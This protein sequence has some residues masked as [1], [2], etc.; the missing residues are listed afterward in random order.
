MKLGKD[1]DCDEQ[2]VWVQSFRQ[3]RAGLTAEPGREEVMTLKA[4]R[5][6]GG[7]EGFRT[8]VC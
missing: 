5:L 7:A 8:M 1:T 6:P 3:G 2:H 4:V